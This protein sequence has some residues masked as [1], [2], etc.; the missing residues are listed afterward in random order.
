MKLSNYG[1]VKAGKW[2]LK[3]SLKS[4]IAFELYNFQNERVIYA[5]VVDNKVKY[6]GI[7]ENTRTTLKG[8]MERYQ[9]FVGAGTN[10]RIAG[11]IKKCL[12]QRK[13]VKI[14]ALKPKSELRYE[15]VYVDL[16]KGL[17]NPLIEKLKPEWNIKNIKGNEG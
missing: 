15:G 2:K 4:G 14:L 1:F 5:F 3:N 13:E 10:E 7:C 17:E 12:K 9:H 8:R 6:I 11:N 16:V